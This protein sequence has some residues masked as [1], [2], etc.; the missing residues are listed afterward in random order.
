MSLCLNCI[1]FTL[2]GKEVSKNKYVDIFLLWL[3]NLIKFGELKRDDFIRCFIDDVTKK[4]LE[5][6]TIFFMLMQKLPCKLQI[7]GIPRPKTA[8]EGMMWKYYFVNYTQD[9]YMYCDIDCMTIGP[10]HSLVGSIHDDTIAVH[11]EGPIE[12]ANYGAAFSKEQLEALKGL[13]GFSAGKFIVRGKNTLESLF[14]LV[15]S[16]QLGWIGD[17]FYTVE[18][19][20]F[21][22]AIY[23]SNQSSINF[24]LLN[25]DTISVNGN[26]YK[27]GK[28][29]LMDFMGEPGNGDFHYKKISE[30]FILFYSGIW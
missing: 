13:T 12:D 27:K 11:C 16:L 25:G 7:L 17:S 2:E 10:I 9:I 18:Q 30:I 22:R 26:N 4:Y 1:V 8:L 24:D 3:A 5:D 29:I 6:E 19:P 23:H 15:N 20:F 28:T 14:K 21:N